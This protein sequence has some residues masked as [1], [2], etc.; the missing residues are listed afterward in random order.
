MRRAAQLS[1]ADLAAADLDAQKEIL[2]LLNIRVIP[3]E[4]GYTIQGTL[5][6]WPTEPGRW[7]QRLLSAVDLPVRYRQFC[8]DNKHSVE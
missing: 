5:P 1:T 8:C 3:S 6:Y 7:R 2:D 4:D